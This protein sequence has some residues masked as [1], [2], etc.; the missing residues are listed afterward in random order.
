MQG[1]K[2]VVDRM[3][4]LSIPGSLYIDGSFLTQKIDPKDVD[5]VLISS[6]DLIKNATPAQD[7]FFSAIAEQRFLQEHHCDSY[8]TWY[9]P[10]DS[11]DLDTYATR[12]QGWLEWFGHDRNKKPKGIA[13]IEAHK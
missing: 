4:N 9:V 2:H 8:L 6:T 7:E 3:K 10:E 11:T 12:R 1:I 5:F 13:V